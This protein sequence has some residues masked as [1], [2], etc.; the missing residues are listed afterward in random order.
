LEQNSD[1]QEI[2]LQK[3]NIDRY[4]MEKKSGKSMEREEFKKMMDYLL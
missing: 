4:F 2:A 3:L 1:R